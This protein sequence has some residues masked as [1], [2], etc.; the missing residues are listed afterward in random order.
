[1]IS[2]GF[3]SQCSVVYALRCLCFF[4]WRKPGSCWSCW[5]SWHQSCGGVPFWHVE[6]NGCGISEAST[7]IIVETQAVYP[8]EGN[9]R[10]CERE[11]ECTAEAS[12]SCENQNM[13]HQL[14]QNINQSCGPSAKPIPRGRTWETGNTLLEGLS[15]LG[16]HILAWFSPG[17]D[18]ELQ[19][20]MLALL[21]FNFALTQCLS[22]PLFLHFGMKM[23]TV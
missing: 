1:M 13:H 9:A 7:Q 11:A 3:I 5:K 2:S 18:Q 12:G 4:D 22:V 20:A 17:A 15:A 10:S 21:G 16:V 23:F 6:C 19:N 8:G 14:D